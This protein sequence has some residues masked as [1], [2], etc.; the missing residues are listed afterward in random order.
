MHLLT[1]QPTYGAKIKP[2]VAIASAAAAVHRDG[3]DVLGL[4]VRR[5]HQDPEDAA[6]DPPR[7]VV[8][9]RKNGQ[10]CTRSEDDVNCVAQV[11]ADSAGSRIFYHD[12]RSTVLVESVLL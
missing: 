8:T 11:D 4:R 5:A 9:D 6:L 7:A 1:V 10:V 12:F 2:V 3:G